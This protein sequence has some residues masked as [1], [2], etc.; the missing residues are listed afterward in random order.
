MLRKGEIKRVYSVTHTTCLKLAREVEMTV[1][2][3]RTEGGFAV[4]LC[5]SGENETGMHLSY[6]QARSLFRCLTTA[7]FGVPYD[8]PTRDEII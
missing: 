5:N 8:I 1:E 4:H 3:L 6:E 2:L 7:V